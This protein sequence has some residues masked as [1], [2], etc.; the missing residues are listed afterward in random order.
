MTTEQDLL[1]AVA[2]ML[3]HPQFHFPLAAAQRQYREHYYGLS[4]AALLEDLYYDAFSNFL[5]QF[6]PGVE[7]ARPPRGE[8]GWDYRFQGSPVSHKVGK[9]PQEIAALWD[10]TRTDLTEWTFDFPVAYLCSGYAPRKFVL[11]DGL[12]E[13]GVMGL[14][15]N[16]LQTMVRGRPI[17]VL[18]WGTGNEATILHK[19]KPL[20]DTSLPGVLGFDD[21]WPVVAAQLRSGMAANHIEVVSSTAV[22]RRVDEAHFLPGSHVQ[23]RSGHRPGV[24]VFP[25]ASLVKVPVKTNNRAVLLS[26]ETVARL[27]TE[28]VAAGLFAPLPM[29]FAAFAGDRPPDLYLTQRAEFDSLFSPTRSRVEI[30]MEP[31]TID[32]AGEPVDGRQQSGS[33]HGISGQLELQ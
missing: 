15:G 5:A 7:L 14:T 22:E 1:G 19:V 18:A 28:S 23:V 13:V 30:D 21:L 9:A 29:W 6:H 10:A 27:M 16:P 17:V 12:S 11:A 33:G 20:V 26:K 4:S 2:E 24:Y 8:R 25:A 31:D 3:R 32:A